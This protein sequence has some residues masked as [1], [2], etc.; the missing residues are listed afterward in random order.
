MYQ[1]IKGYE[2]YQ[3]S[4]NGIV[5]NKKGKKR[6]TY[7]TSYG[8]EHIQLHKNGKRKTFRIH[9]LV[10]EHF[11][12]NYDNKTEVNHIDGNKLNNNVKNLEWCTRSENQLHAYKIGLQKLGEEHY[13]SK[14]KKKDIIEIRDMLDKGISHFDI[15]KHFNVSKS[16]ITKINNNK[17]W[18]HI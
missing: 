11:I 13:N 7:I 8:Y 2:N 16:L 12:P 9:R 5:I 18:K 4:D 1:T 14:L 3:I 15:S 6:K 10:A 17:I